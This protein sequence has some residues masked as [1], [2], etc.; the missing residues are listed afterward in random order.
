MQAIFNSARKLPPFSDGPQNIATLK[1]IDTVN[2]AANPLPLASQ[3]VVVGNSLCIEL[4]EVTEAVIDSVASGYTRFVN[5]L[6]A[7]ENSLSNLGMTIGKILLEIAQSSRAPESVRA[8]VKEQ[9][10]ISFRELALALLENQ[11]Q[12]NCAQLIASKTQASPTSHVS[13]AIEQRRELRAHFQNIQLI[14]NSGKNCFFTD[15]D[16]TYLDAAIDLVGH[17]DRPMNWLEFSIISIYLHCFTLDLEQSWQQHYLSSDDPDVESCAAQLEFNLI[18]ENIKNLCQMTEIS[19]NRQAAAEI[20]AHQTP[21]YRALFHD[22]SYTKT[23]STSVSLGAAVGCTNAGTS[24][25]AKT[26]VTRTQL[27]M[28][29]DERYMGKMNLTALGVTLEAK[30]KVLGLAN[31]QS[32]VTA[33]TGRG[34]YIE[35]NTPEHYMQEHFAEMVEEHKSDPVVKQHLSSV[36]DLLRY[37][38]SLAGTFLDCSTFMDVCKLKEREAHFKRHSADIQQGLG[39]LK[40][41]A[42][43]YFP[44]APMT[45]HSVD[46]DVEDTSQPPLP[47]PLRPQGIAEAESAEASISSTAPTT[48]TLAPIEPTQPAQDE[49]PVALS[50]EDYLHLESRLD[51]MWNNANL[52]TNPLVVIDA[53]FEADVDVTELDAAASASMGLAEGVATISAAVDVNRKEHVLHYTHLT[54]LCQILAR[55]DAGNFSQLD[56]DN[57]NNAILIQSQIIEKNVANALDATSPAKQ[58]FELRGLLNF[59]KNL[60]VRIEKLD[61]D[62]QLPQRKKTEVIRTELHQK[63][64]ADNAEEFLHNIMILNAALYIKT[65]RLQKLSPQECSQLKKALLDFETELLT[66]SFPCDIKAL[67]KMS[68]FAEKVDFTILDRQLLI[69]AKAALAI[70]EVKLTASAGAS[71]QLHLMTRDHI[72]PLRDGEYFFGLLTLS[73]SIA[74]NKATL[75][76]LQQQLNLSNLDLSMIIP[77]DMLAECSGSLRILFFKSNQYPQL[78]YRFMVGRAIGEVTSKLSGSFGIPVA[79]GIEIT[80]GF[81]KLTDETSCLY[82]FFSHQSLFQFGLQYTHEYNIGLI[83]QKTGVVNPNSYWLIIRE[84]QKPAFQKLFAHYR[85]ESGNSICDEL[86]AFLPAPRTEVQQQVIDR[87]D[88][89]THNYAQEPH[90]DRLY[91]AALTSFENLLQVYSALAL[92]IKWSSPLLIQQ[93]LNIAPHLEKRIDVSDWSSASLASAESSDE[94]SSPQNSIAADTNYVH[95]ISDGDS[96]ETEL[97]ANG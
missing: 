19:W 96:D 65:T 77:Q 62:G 50:F 22:P 15:L 21:Q 54:P 58:L 61:R 3:L 73:T 79:P 32:S 13:P 75:T 81:S 88:T 36:H 70:P 38:A 6:T 68:C 48:I 55:H 28:M 83:N 90:N 2:D 24:A 26:T 10:D 11:R 9:Q 72:H 43:K 8:W 35:W 63:Y 29:D 78:G 27:T 76:M 91:Q 5:A 45:L 71:A 74:S 47:M 16:K 30:T 39:L 82:E 34:S 51:T 97:T 42:E 60:Q 86:N 93:P 4:I 1:V 57:V 41:A 52:T 40:L 84:A 18:A 87:F 31:A 95:L 94:E 20:I 67:K 33:A 46:C 12:D 64:S 7:V 59:Y 25:G 37:D 44:P 85:P 14:V 69:A 53:P 80:T 56:R 89:A 92:N 17:S 49:Q 66:P 23:E